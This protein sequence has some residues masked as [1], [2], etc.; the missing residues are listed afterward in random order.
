MWFQRIC[1]FLFGIFCFKFQ[2]HENT[3]LSKSKCLVWLMTFCIYSKINKCYC[4][5]KRKEFWTKRYF[6]L[7]M[8][9]KNRLQSRRRRG[10]SRLFNRTS[11]KNAENLDA[12]IQVVLSGNLLTHIKRYVLFGPPDWFHSLSVGIFSPLTSA[13]FFAATECSKWVFKHHPIRFK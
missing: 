9:L 13:A 7:K 11:L 10:G 1:L 2:K 6:F 4:L 12:P 8:R 3:Q 5:Q